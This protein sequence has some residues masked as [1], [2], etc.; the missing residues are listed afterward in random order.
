MNSNFAVILGR[1]AARRQEVIT[2]D[3]VLADDTV[4]EVDTTG[5]RE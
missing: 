1:E 4:L 2:W 5:L 3:D